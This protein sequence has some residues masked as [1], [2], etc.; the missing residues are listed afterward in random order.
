MGAQNS[1]RHGMAGEHALTDIGQLVLFTIFLA[2]WITDSFLFRYSVFLAV[3]VPVSIRFAVG[4]AA[5]VA[6]AFLALSAH[7]AVFGGP[8]REPGVISKGVFSFVRHPMYLGS[9]VFSLGLVIMTL[10]VSSA[11]VSL[12]IFLFYYL[13]AKYEERLLVKKFGAEYR[14]YQAR[15]PMFLPLKFR[16]FRVPLNLNRR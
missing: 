14:K 11:A 10:S 4:G 8:D 7:K 12:L 13:A 15:V 2:T 3:H 6:S 1:N 16:S 9:W 5:L